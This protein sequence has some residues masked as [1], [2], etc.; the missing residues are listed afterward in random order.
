MLACAQKGGVGR[1]CERYLPWAGPLAEAARAL[2]AGPA[3]AQLFSAGASGQSAPPAA[4]TPGRG[5]ERGMKGGA[6]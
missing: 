2:S 5:G 1:A 3:G 4:V 6:G